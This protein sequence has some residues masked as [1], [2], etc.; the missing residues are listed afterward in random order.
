ME[1]GSV[2]IL[3]LI[4]TLVLSLIV[5][6]LLTVGTTELYTT[7]NYLMN[8]LSHYHCLQGLEIIR[9]K[10]QTDN[11]DDPTQVVL[12]GT[13]I[14]EGPISK[15]F[16]IG[17]LEDLQA[18][19]PSNVEIFK[20]FPPPPPLGM[21]LGSNTNIVPVIFDVKVTSRITQGTK[22]T[23]SETQSGVYTLMKEY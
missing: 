5:T 20:G 9:D 1:R 10:I 16:T 12:P 18:G 23:Y 3:T 4:A 2:L 21:S 22:S 17:T 15:Y 11:S 7:Q 14:E 19:N 8:R 6:G 13:P